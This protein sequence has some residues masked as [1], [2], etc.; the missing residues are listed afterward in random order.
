VTKSELLAVTRPEDLFPA[1]KDGA[2]SIYRKMSKFWHP[3]V[4]TGS[5]DVFTHLTKLY[6]EALDKINNGRWEGPA[7]VQFEGMDK[8]YYSYQA[9]T[10]F[11]FP[12]GHAIVADEV[13]VYLFYD[14]APYG[15]ALEWMTKQR[16]FA[17]PDMRTE[18]ER[19]LPHASAT[20]LLTDHR[21]LLAVK[22]TKDLVRLRDVVTHYGPIEPV[23]MAWMISSLL[24]LACYFAHANIVHHDIS[25]DTYFIS[26]EHHSGALLGGWWSSATRGDT[27]RTVP[28]RTFGVMPFNAK[29]FKRASTRTDLELIRLTARECMHMPAPEPMQTWLTN[30]GTGHAFDQY[31]QWTDVL[32][33]TF[34]PRR[35]TKFPL[36]ASDV[37]R[38][39][40]KVV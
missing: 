23:H 28:R 32:I 29:M 18:F 7:F 35:F 11:P 15:R 19:Y 6:R 10:S 36:T 3:D 30:V 22:K 5:A 8:T 13:L 38:H 16:P 39:Q 37:Y 33:K 24:N 26:P 20:A 12:Y 27:I 1:D 14:A 9:R 31:K 25:P 34:G 2:Q 40:G 17:S 21:Q 4:A